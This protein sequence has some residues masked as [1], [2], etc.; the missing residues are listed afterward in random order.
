MKHPTL[1]LLAAPQGAGQLVGAAL[2]D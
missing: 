1:A 2:P